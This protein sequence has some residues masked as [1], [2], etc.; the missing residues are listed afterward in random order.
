M[1]EKNYSATTSDNLEFEIEQLKNLNFISENEIKKIDSFIKRK[2]D[3]I[4]ELKKIELIQ[5]DKKDILLTS[6][7]D[8]NNIE[9]ELNIKLFE[10]R[11]KL[12]ELKF[13]EQQDQTELN[14][15]SKSIKKYNDIFYNEKYDK[16]YI[17][18]E[19]VIEEE[20]HS[21]SCNRTNSLNRIYNKTQENINHYD[22][23]KNI[24]NSSLSN[25][26]RKLDNNYGIIN[27][28]QNFNL[29]INFNFNLTNNNY[30]EDKNQTDVQ[31]SDD[32]VRSLPNLDFNHLKN[33]KKTNLKYHQN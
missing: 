1:N 11:Q 9:T 31:I 15:L 5:E 16:K 19:Q 14:F 8:I 32:F 22:F 25:R 29:N 24:F 4:K 28:K 13:I 20:E 10:L 33:K 6:N 12:D 26:K 17:D 30:K 21:K 23:D 18:T 3:K 27:L 7:K 2:R